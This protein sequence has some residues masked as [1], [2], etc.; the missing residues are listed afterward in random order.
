MRL[1]VKLLGL[2]LL[3]MALN[4]Y[5]FSGV[6]RQAAWF[7]IRCQYAQ[8]FK[9]GRMEERLVE[10]GRQYMTAYGHWPGEDEP[11]FHAAWPDGTTLETRAARP[12]CEDPPVADG[13]CI[14]A[15]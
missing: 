13:L 15:R 4:Q 6:R 3:A 2:V 7:A 10:E 14:A 1:Y 11:A 12:S 5:A 9:D 8:A